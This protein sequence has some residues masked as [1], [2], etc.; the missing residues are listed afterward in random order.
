MPLTKRCIGEAG[1]VEF[2]APIRAVVPAIA[3]QRLRQALAISAGEI[4][5]AA[6]FWRGVEKGKREV[7]RSIR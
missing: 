1:A 4:Q 7:G 3:H 5:G 6:R 2:V